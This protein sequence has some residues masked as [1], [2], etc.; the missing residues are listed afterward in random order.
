MNPRVG[1]VWYRAVVYKHDTSVHYEEWH[2]RV[3]TP[4]GIWVGRY[5]QDPAPLSHKENGRQWYTFSTR[6]IQRTK[7]LALE[8]LVYRTGFWV[9]KE[10][11]RLEQAEARYKMLT[12]TEHPPETPRLRTI[13]YFPNY[14]E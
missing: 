2:V 8:R 7:E 6:Y 1:D 9:R 13:G 3:V 5:H 12:G 4:K 14:N 11:A 10:R